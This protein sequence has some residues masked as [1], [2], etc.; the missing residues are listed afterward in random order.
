MDERWEAMKFN[1]EEFT[2]WLHSLVDEHPDSFFLIAVPVEEEIPYEAYDMD[3]TVHFRHVCPHHNMHGTLDIELE[4]DGHHVIMRG[5]QNGQRAPGFDSE[6]PVVQRLANDDDALRF[7][8][9]ARRGFVVQ[10]FEIVDT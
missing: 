5:Y 10:D 4:L 9:R 2:K 3:K 8:L 7:Y 1:S 6:W